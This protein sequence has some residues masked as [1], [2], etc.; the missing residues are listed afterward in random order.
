MREFPKEGK[1]LFHSQSELR[2]SACEPPRLFYSLTV[3][4]RSLGFASVNSLVIVTIAVI[5][6]FTPLM[7]L[8][9]V[10]A[11]EVNQNRPDPMPSPPH[12]PDPDPHVQD[13]QRGGEKDVSIDKNDNIDKKENHPQQSQERIDVSGEGGKLDMGNDIE[14][15][16]LD[17]ITG[18]SQL[19]MGSVIIG[20][21]P[22]ENRQF[23]C[24]VT[25]M[26]STHEGTALMHFIFKV[27]V[28][29]GTY[30]NIEKICYGKANVDDNAKVKVKIF[31]NNR[32]EVEMTGLKMEPEHPKGLW[33]PH[34]K[35]DPFK[36][37]KNEHHKR[38]PLYD[39]P[40]YVPQQR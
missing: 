14:V 16:R 36:G 3:L 17:T 15:Y 26:V 23:M 6:T 4:Y 21:A 8:P 24:T 2:L 25:Y 37:E 27:T 20:D 13:T 30:D 38:T 40:I 31:K 34:E 11:E 28:A 29:P 35:H 19:V 1:V 9:T 18:E 12:Q 7:L 33:P 39:G 32:M 5:A 10:F 22:D